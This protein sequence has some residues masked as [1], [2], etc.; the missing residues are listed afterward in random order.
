V[1]ITSHLNPVS[2]FVFGFFAVLVFREIMGQD[3]SDGL[4]RMEPLVASLLKMLSKYVHEPNSGLEYMIRRQLAYVSCHP[5][6]AQFPLIKV[7]TER[8]SQEWAVK[9]SGD[10]ALLVCDYS[11]NLH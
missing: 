4:P 11:Q 5:D 2:D 8:L 1:N 9:Q 3:F 6:S 7:V 10:E